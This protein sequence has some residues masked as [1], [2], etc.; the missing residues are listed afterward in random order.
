MLKEMMLRHG[1]VGAIHR[2]L[3]LTLHRIAFG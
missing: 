1:P 2:R 3:L